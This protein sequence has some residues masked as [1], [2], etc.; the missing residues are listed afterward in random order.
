[1]L[2]LTRRQDAVVDRF[3][4][5]A[6]RA[7]AEQCVLL[8]GEHLIRDAVAAGIPL[9]VVMATHER[10]NQLGELLS[11]LSAMAATPELYEGAPSVLEAASPVKTPS[12]IVALAR[13]Q[14]AALDEA[15]SGQ[16]PL[17]LGAVDVQD[18]GNFGAIVRS[19]DALGASGV[20]AAGA[21][22][23]PAGW[24]AL[25]GAMG[26]AFRIPVA[27]APTDAALSAAKANGLRV[28]AASMDGVP[29]DHCDLTGPVMLLLGSE[30]LGL[31]PAALGAADDR[32]AIPMRP[33]VNS[34]NVAVSAAL[35]LYE[36]RR[37]R[38]PA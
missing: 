30:G 4:R 2:R 27:K 18:P 33:G 11:S 32:I 14:P 29:L 10:W 23:D 15:L 9:D 16:P 12:G 7:P 36:A 26:S 28:Y 37:Q 8:D 17:V 31:P 24:K 22:A 3:R 35:L 21:S 20:V 34:L 5:A 13:W 1:M 6:R 38:S 19:A 25:R